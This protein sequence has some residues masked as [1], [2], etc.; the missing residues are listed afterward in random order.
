[1]KVDFVSSFCIHHSYNRPPLSHL[2]LCNVAT[3]KACSKE[4]RSTVQSTALLQ[5]TT[6][7]EETRSNQNLYSSERPYEILPIDEVLK[8]LVPS[9]KNQSEESYSNHILTGLFNQQAHTLLAEVGPNELSPPRKT[10]IWELWFQQF[11]DTLVKILVGVALA[12]AAFSASEVWEAVLENVESVNVGEI[13]HVLS[14]SPELKSTILQ[15]FVEPAIIIAIL[16]INA[17][18]GTWQDLSARS[19]LEALEKMQPRLAT[20][21]RSDN[22][23]DGAS[24]SQWITDFDATQLVPGDIIR[25]RVGDSIP[26][27]ARLV[28]L[29]SSTMYVDESSLTGESVSAD[30]LPGDEGLDDSHKDALTE[31]STM[32]IQDQSA[33]LFSGCLVTRGSGIAMVVR[34]GPASQIGKIQST[35]AEAQIEVEE[36]KTP[37]G[38]QLDE[39]GTTLSY[40]IGAICIA[41]WV[42][43]VPHFTDSV[44]DTWIEGAIYYAKVGVALGVAGTNVRCR[45]QMHNLDTCLELTLFF[46][47]TTQPYPKGYPL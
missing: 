21:L 9:S 44:F 25:L 23:E 20:V 42:A 27:D 4:Y 36:R 8:F 17:L 5:T 11:D 39:F 43:S 33:M 2:S 26:A 6:N 45:I 16:L 24:T 41:V 15:S 19:S 13:V 46:T 34:T 3:S 28:S 35:L 18:V 22:E 7:N 14:S 1:M 30:K 29:A 32:P 37:L 12:S 10:T 47:L 31:G 38:E 40:V